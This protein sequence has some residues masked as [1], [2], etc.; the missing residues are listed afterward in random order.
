MDTTEIDQWINGDLSWEDLSEK[1][2]TAIDGEVED[3]KPVASMDLVHKSVAEKRF[4]LGP[5]YIP[6]RLDAHNEWTDSDELQAGLWDYVRKGDRGIRLQH[7][8]DIVAGEW[9]EAM[10]LPVPVQ[11]QKAANGETVEYP[12]GTVFLGVVWKQW[13]WDLVKN[14]KIKGFSIGG[15]SARLPI[16]PVNKAIKV[17]PTFIPALIRVLGKSYAV[18]PDE[19]GVRV[20]SG[21]DFIVFD[22]FQVDLV[23]KSVSDG[24]VADANQVL[25]FSQAILT[26]GIDHGL[27]VN[28]GDSWSFVKAKFGSRVEAGKYAEHVRRAVASGETPLGVVEFSEN[29]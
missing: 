27:W 3:A 10:Q 28:T 16:E 13:A 9:V 23:A 24:F 20:S 5:W 6:N 19:G 4:T 11:M 21:S 7:N 18:R 12:E 15:S 1:A 25:A 22:P 2:Q 8:R 14:G 17:S 29:L 26:G